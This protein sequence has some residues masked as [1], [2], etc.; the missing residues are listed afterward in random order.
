MR[1]RAALVLA[2]GVVL[3]LAG[4][5]V[6]LT[7]P[8][9]GTLVVQVRDAPSDFS[10]VLVTFSEVRVH[11][12]DAADESDWVN[13]TLASASIDFMSLGNLTKVLGLDQIPAGKY[14][15]IR[16]VVSAVTATTDGG[17]SVA[18]IVPDGILKTTTSFDLAA[19]GV[20]TITVDFDLAHSMYEAGGVWIFTPVIGSVQVG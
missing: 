2:L 14:T 1:S 12:A 19:G 11:P 13:V 6:Y 17:Q 3:L 9:T 7:F 16:I 20:T 5:A 18:M 15:Q 8:A 10:H 4:I